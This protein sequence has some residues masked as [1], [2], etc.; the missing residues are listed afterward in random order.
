MEFS[1][2]GYTHPTQGTRTQLNKS[3]QPARVIRTKGWRAIDRIEKACEPSLPFS[4]FM[5]DELGIFVGE[6]TVFFCMD[7][8]DWATNT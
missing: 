5:V 3:S 1:F 4:V 6:F 8:R 2:N 7:D